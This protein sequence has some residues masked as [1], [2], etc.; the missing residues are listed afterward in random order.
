MYGNESI[1]IFAT[2]MSRIGK[3]P[4]NLPQDVQVKVNGNEIVVKGS[5]GELIWR[6]SPDLKVFVQDGGIIVE[7]SSDTKQLR[8]LHGTTRSIIANMV[9]G[10]SEGYER[11]LEIVGIGYRVEVQGKKLLLTL[12]YSH[13][14]EYSLPEGITARVDP[15][16]TQ[17]ILKG[18]DKQLIGQ[19]AADLRALRPPDIY[20]GKGIRY[21]GEKI[22]LKAGKTGKK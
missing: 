11:I 22:K 10:V 16:Q 5:R 12:G 17:I 20:K 9:R 6:F 15:K 2:N 3:S 21:T 1:I 14:I 8:A 18:I 19:V 7:R 13:P 4:I